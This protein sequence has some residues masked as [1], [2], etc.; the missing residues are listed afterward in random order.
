MGGPETQ[1]IVLT[2]GNAGGLW[3]HTPVDWKGN[4]TGT[5]P[6]NWP[7]DAVN[8]QPGLGTRP[9]TPLPGGLGTITATPGVGQLTIAWSTVDP[10]NS[11]VD[12]G[13]T[14]SYG[15]H[16]HDPS[17]VTSH[18]IVVTGLTSGQVQHYR[19]T[20]A[21]PGSGYSSTSIDYTATPT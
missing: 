5:K 13:P 1:A 2:T 9:G 11:S 14:T 19:I 15:R 4:E 7:T 8:G 12:I 21:M 17:I 16:L 6:S 3:T 10:S 18:S 20:S